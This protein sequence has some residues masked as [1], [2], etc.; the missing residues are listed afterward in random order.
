LLYLPI[1]LV[2]DHDDFAIQMGGTV[3]FFSPSKVIKEI[4]VT[5]RLCQETW[6]LQQSF[7]CWK[8]IQLLPY[9]NP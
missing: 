5:A 9:R 1:F 4:D 7:I 6:L 3:N 8:S 2:I